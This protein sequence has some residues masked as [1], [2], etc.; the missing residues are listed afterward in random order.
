MEKPAPFKSFHDQ[1]QI[2]QGLQATSTWLQYDR[3]LL[4]HAFFS[5][6]LDP[7]QA[8]LAAKL[9]ESLELEPARSQKMIQKITDQ[10]RTKAGKTNWPHNKLNQPIQT[11]LNTGIITQK[12]LFWAAHQSWDDSVKSAAKT[13]LQLDFLNFTNAYP[14]EKSTP[15]EIIEGKNFSESEIR[16]NLL[17]SGMVFGVYCMVALI[18]VILMLANIFGVF[19]INY[20]MA[21]LILF[22]APIMAGA[23]YV[24]KRNIKKC[25]NHQRG[26]KAEYEACQIL[27]RQL[28]QTWTIFRNIK[29]PHR[30]DDLDIVLL[31]THGIYVLE[32]K[33]WRGHFRVQQHQWHIQNKQGHWKKTSFGNP[34]QQAKGNAVRLRDTLKKQGIDITYVKPIVVWLPI[35]FDDERRLPP[36]TMQVEQASELILF[37]QDLAA[38]CEQQQQLGT[39]MDATTVQKIKDYLIKTNASRSHPL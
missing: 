27:Q 25:L 8:L 17:Y 23:L 22:F 28:N 6:D 29:L 38:W 12:D 24:I 15:A 19:K 26:Y 3:A 39:T 34:H 2:D 9:S 30:S 7:S 33:A 37:R 14:T 21:F 20:F 13:L 18:F 32:V 4:W 31:S 10:L 5:Q 1:N 16:K 35:V 11:L 36:P